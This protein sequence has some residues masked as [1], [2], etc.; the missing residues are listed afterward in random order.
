V[1]KKNIYQSELY[2]SEKGLINSS[3]K[4]FP[5]NTVLVAMY[6]ATAGQVGILRFESSTNQAVCGILPNEKILP[7]FLYYVFLARKEKLVSQAVGNAQPNIS[8]IKI[9]NTLIPNIEI[10]K[11]KEIVQ[12]LDELQAETKRLEEIY[13]QKLNCLEELKQAILHKAFNGEL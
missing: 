9:K 6:G 3:A 8:Q 1:S 10:E 11:Q 13:Q 12:K 7:E 2:I 4:L 5:K